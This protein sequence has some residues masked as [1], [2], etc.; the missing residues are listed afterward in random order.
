MPMTGNFN[1]PGPYV[2]DIPPVS[3]AWILVGPPGTVTAADL[4]ARMAAMSANGGGS[5]L[6]PPSATPWVFDD[7]LLMASN[8]SI[9]LS[10]GVRITRP[11]PFTLTCTTT[12]G[13]QNV[14]VTAGDTSRLKTGY[15]KAQLVVGA[16]VPINARVASVTDATRFQL[17]ANATASATVTLTFH[18]AHNVIRREGVS[19]ARVLAPWG[20]ATLDGNGLAGPI[21][22]SQEDAIRNCI[23]T[24]LCTDVETSGVLLTSAFYHGEIGVNNSGKINLED[25]RSFRNGYR[26]VHY[27]GDSPSMVVEDLTADKI[28][29]VEDGQIAFQVSGNDWNTGIFICFDACKRYQ[30]GRLRARRLPGLGV[31]LNGN[32]PGGIRS[33][34]ISYDSVVTEDCFI[35]VG[36][37]NGLRQS[38]IGSIQAKGSI[39]QIANVTLGAGPV[40]LPRY[41]NNNGSLLAGAIMMPMV[42]P[43]GTDM[44]QFYRGMAVL[45]Q[46]VAAIRGVIRRIWSV[47]AATRTLMVFADDDGATR[48]WDIALDNTTATVT[49]G[50]MRNGL[51]L[52]TSSNSTQ[53]MQDVCIGELQVE[54][55]MSRAAVSN[56]YG[57]GVYAVDGLRFGAIQIRDCIDGCSLNSTQGLVIGSYQSRNVA[58]RRTGNDAS[59]V[60]LYIGRCDSV[61]VGKFDARS[62]GTGST[63]RTNAAL[64]QF[65]NGSSNVKILDVVAQNGNGSNFAVDWSSCTNIVIG[66]F[67]NA[68][69]TS[70]TPVGTVAA[71]GS[72]FRYGLT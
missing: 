6:F 29:S 48:P 61:H 58:D 53:Q 59:S 40:Q 10:P 63:T 37:F 33:S 72:V 21:T 39:T 16:G 22:G 62:T 55:S 42:L 8:T 19:N 25:I 56:T 30:V 52:S 18:W 1:G 50:T 45:L 28:E 12:A 34:Q 54:G 32:I 38:R 68:A 15:Y 69:G 27:H 23:R 4:T 47:D 60:D 67:R 3:G 41:H 11:D 49:F 66:D 26:A 20:R 31:H 36:L 24:A 13:S 70:L 35:G 71:N 43:G 64:L 5:L 17:D 46:D 9:I 57:A 7:E 65:P 51:L 2:V 14:T 44:T